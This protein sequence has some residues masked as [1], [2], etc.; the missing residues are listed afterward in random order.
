MVR[1]TS[2]GSAVP[3][4][5]PGLEHL[6]EV[7]CRTT[8]LIATRS[9][10]ARSSGSWTTADTAAPELWREPFL[11]DG[12]TLTFDAA[13]ARVP[14]CDRAAGS[15]G[16]GD[17]HVRRRTGRLSGRRRELVR[18]RPRMRAG[19]ASRC[20]PSITGA[21]RPTR[22]LSADVVPASNFSG[23]SLLP[24]GA[25]AASPA[26]ARPIWRAT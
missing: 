16:V 13:M 3:D 20:R 19:P 6:P 2:A 7:T 26:A 9:R 17:G 5:I 22:R 25:S 23:K 15:R 14:R 4:I 12:R 10:T 21:A 24:A 18:E 11:K 1:I 8:G